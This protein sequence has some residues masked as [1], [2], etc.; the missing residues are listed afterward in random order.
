MDGGYGCE[1]NFSRDFLFI[2][3]ETY[4]MKNTSDIDVAF[5]SIFFCGIFRTNTFL[6]L[7]SA[8]IPSNSARMALPKNLFVYPYLYMGFIRLPTKKFHVRWLKNCI[9]CV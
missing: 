4:E 9:A 7:T 2:K 1:S 8:G 3:I 6:G 5:S